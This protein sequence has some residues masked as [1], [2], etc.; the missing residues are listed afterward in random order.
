MDKLITHRV[1]A[2]LVVGACLLPIVL[3]VLGGTAALLS[4]LGDV[5]GAAVVG[6]VALV[7]GLVWVVNLV[8]LVLTLGIRAVGASSESEE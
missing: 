7:A 2:V 4:A 1:T 6:R 5:T 8:I 3:A